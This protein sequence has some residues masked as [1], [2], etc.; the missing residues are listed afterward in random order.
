MQKLTDI[1]LDLISDIDMYQIMEIVMRRR[2][3]FI[4]QRQRKANNKYMKSCYKDKYL[5]I[6]Y[7]LIHLICMGGQRLDIFQQMDL[8]N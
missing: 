1:K 5:G 3:S 8:N 2:V 7:S 6:Q 4:A